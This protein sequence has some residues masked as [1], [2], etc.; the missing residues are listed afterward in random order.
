MFSLKCPSLLQFD[1]R[2]LAEPNLRTVFHIDR[3]PCDTSMRE[4]LDGVEPDRLRRPFRDLFAAAQRSGLLDRYRVLGG[5]YLIALDGTE[6][7]RSDAVH[8]EACLTKQHKDGRTSYHHQALAGVVVRPGLRTVVPLC[9]EP[10]VR[11]DGRTKN[12]CELNAG[13]RF[14]ADLRR[15]HPHL[16]IVVLIDALYANG[17]F[18]KEAASL[19]MDYIV[20]LKE[21]DQPFLWQRIAEREAAGDRR[22]FSV[23][24]P[25]AGARHD[26]VL[27]D[28]VQLNASHD[29]L[30]LNVVLHSETPAGKED[31][32]FVATWG[33]PLEVKR[34]NALEF[35]RSARCRWK[36]ENETF[37]TLKNRGYQFEHN[38]GHG[39]LHL[40]TVL[41]LLMFLAF[42]VD[43][44]QEA[45]CPVFQAALGSKYCRKE[46]WDH[47][48]SHFLTLPYGSMTELLNSLAAHMVQKPLAK[49]PPLK[50]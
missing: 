46:L 12:D 21:E 22:A 25:E 4:I 3:I 40:A 10:I 35:G 26:F 20:R 42:A 16:P 17:P 24:D 14:L 8:C 29:D 18:L 50:G 13:R 48:R 7:F 28:H 43:Q 44:L 37:N 11:S 5:R 15:E 45:G 49:P 19:R 32:K 27:Y 39:R 34:G 30:F 33:T 41:M 31:A 1:K 47:L 38:F 36:V 6:H 2:R 9:P 23:R